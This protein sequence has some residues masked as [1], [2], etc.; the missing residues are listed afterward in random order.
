ML[1]EIE[2]LTPEC[3]IDE[4]NVGV[5]GVTTPEMETKMRGI[6]KRHRSI[7]LGD[8]NAAPAPARGVVCDIDVGEAK[9]VALR[10]RQ[11]TAPFLV[12]VFELLK[13]LLEAEL[14][15]HSVSEWSSPIVIVLKKNGIDIRM[16]IDYRLLNL[17][18]KLSRYPLPLIDDLLVDFKSEMWFMS[19]DKA[20]GFWAVRM[21]ER[22]KLISA[23]VCPFGHFQWLRMPFGL[24]N[25]PLIYQSII[26]NCLW[27]FVRLPPEEEAMVDQEVL[28]FLNLEPQESL[29]PEVDMRNSGIPSL[30]MTV[31]R[32]NIPTPSQMGPA[33][34][35]SSYIDDIAHGASTWDQ[36]CVDLDALLYRLR[37]WK[38][39]VSLPKSEFGKLTMPF[40]SHEVSADGIRALPK[41]VKG[42][43]DLPFPS[44]YKGVQSFLGSLNYYN[45]F[46]ED[47]SVVAA[48]LY[49]LDEERVRT[50]RNLEAAKK[51]FEIL[52]R[53][54]VSTPLLRHP[55]RNKPFVII[56]HANPWSA[57]AVLGQE[58]EERIHP[59]DE[60][61]AAILGY[62][63][64][65]RE[66]LDEVA[67]TLVPAK[68]RLKVMPPLPGWQ[69]VKAEGHLLEGVTVNDAEYHGLILGLKL[70]LKYDVKE[71]VAVGDSRIVV[72]HLINC[73]QPN[74]Q[75][76]LSEYEDLMKSFV[77]VKLIHVKREFNQAAD[78]LTSK[79]LMLGESWELDDPDEIVHLRLVSRIPEKIMKP[80]EIPSTPATDA[81]RSDQVELGADSS[82]A[83]IPESLATAAEALMVMT[84]SRAESDVGARTPVDQSGYQDERSRGEGCATKGLSPIAGQPGNVTRQTQRDAE[85]EVQAAAHQ[86]AQAER[87]LIEA[88]I[89]QYVQ[90]QQ[91]DAE[92]KMQAERAVWEAQTRQS[93]EELERRLKESEAARMEDQRTAKNIQEFHVRQLRDLRATSAKVQVDAPTVAPEP[94]TAESTGNSRP[95]VATVQR[96]VNMGEGVEVRS[97]PG[98][99]NVPSVVL[100]QLRR[101]KML[102]QGVTDDADATDV[103]SQTKKK[104]HKSK[105]TKVLRKKPRYGEDPSDSSG[106]SSSEESSDDLSGS[107]EDSLYEDT[108]SRLVL[109]S[110]AGAGTTMLT[111]HPY[112]NS[113]TLGMFDEKASISDRK[114]WWEKFTNM[115]V[116][117]G[118]T[119]Q[120][121]IR[122]LKMKMPSVKSSES[123]SDF[124]YRLNEAAV[125]AGIKYHKSKKEREEHI[126]RFLKN[127][128]DSQ[129]KVVLRK[130]R[131][132]VLEDLVYVLKQDRD[133]VVDGDAV[134]DE[135]DS[136]SS[137]K[138]DFRA[139]NIPSSRHRP[140]GRA[141][142]GLSEDEAG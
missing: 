100:D 45:K 105:L 58:H 44:T 29:K 116:Q 78:Y 106:S 130:Q 35:R 43:E 141:F 125:K 92:M 56:P 33:L 47:L 89:A 94:T 72:Q 53:K 52:K 20:S 8:G 63:I 62:G 60:D 90:Q 40:L 123:A 24:K 139:D 135:Y 22:A 128:K 31:F 59:K 84:R 57:C 79:T 103:R 124:F 15:E 4:A 102:Q 81:V 23:F 42:I 16:C 69:V 30:N 65:R 11:I 99:K 91:A 46:I 134:V 50:G 109:P 83:G 76:R 64:T 70:A 17:L 37:Y 3:N 19:L 114:N 104:P 121:K 75:R 73:N 1:P 71:L 119:S 138:R 14:I 41:I 136:S 118:W 13:K 77:S 85:A 49:E 68:G 97:E 95:Q 142:I 26:N 74:L 25:A 27:G 51:S 93:M 120:V 111:L 80:S 36:L 38:I 34:G 129:L 87:M 9:P 67:E 127:L 140:K 115:S 48:V 131:F 66:H 55:D 96:G 108:Q 12:K 2:E 98:L 5:P 133:A 54:I 122:E 107:S 10:A 110:A 61:L 7:F 86:A 6:L 101:N 39:S 126:K 117:G 113:A 132:K 112:V 88:A 137:P 21:T 18:I 82:D 28:E 32:R